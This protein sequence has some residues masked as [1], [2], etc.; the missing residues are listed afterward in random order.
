MNG[1]D[2]KQQWQDWQAHD[3][4]FSQ[5]IITNSLPSIHN[6]RYTECQSN[7]LGNLL[8]HLWGRL[9]TIIAHVGWTGWSYYNALD[10]AHPHP[11]NTL[12]VGDRLVTSTC[13]WTLMPCLCLTVPPMYGQLALSFYRL[14]LDI[15][16]CCEIYPQ[17]TAT[18]A[19]W[20]PLVI[21][22]D[23]SYTMLLRNI[24]KCK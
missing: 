15:G 11:L 12:Y 14:H 18:I 19:N 24:T 1:K 10:T 6:W 20:H 2:C 7:N 21:V 5:V 4:Y 9:T 17:R 23:F 13:Y 3:L 22:V 8:P 16:N